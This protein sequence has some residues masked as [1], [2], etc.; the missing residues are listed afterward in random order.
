[1]DRT[2]VEQ[3]KL[4]VYQ[5]ALRFVAFSDGLLTELAGKISARD[6]LDRA[7][8]SIV[9][10]I[11]EGNGKRSKGDRCRYLDIARGP[12]LE[13]DACLDVLAVKKMVQPSRVA[14]GKEILVGVV[15]MIVGLRGAFG[16]QVRE[17]QA[18]YPDGE[19]EH[20]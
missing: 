8:T 13:C 16:G 1:M 10:N 9:V 12:A 5:D 4:R 17:E 7:A 14:E 11:A 18:V 15:S 3:K 2:H 19:A 6:L 20:D